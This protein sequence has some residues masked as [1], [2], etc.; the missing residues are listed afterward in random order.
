[1]GSSCVAGEGKT[2]LALSGRENAKRRF[3][4]KRAPHT[5]VRSRRIYLARTGKLYIYI[6]KY[7]N[8][9]YM[10]NQ[11]IILGGARTL[12]ILDRMTPSNFPRTTQ[13]RILRRQLIPT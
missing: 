5:Y 9:V 6:R 4:E 3:I 12:Q 1:M 11:K 2:S 8:K 7:E 13:E 10:Y